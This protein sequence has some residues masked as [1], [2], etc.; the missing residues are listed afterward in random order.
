MS[1][2]LGK[3][4]QKKQYW[5]ASKLWIEFHVLFNCLTICFFILL[6]LAQC[7][8]K[9]K[10]QPKKKKIQI[11]TQRWHSVYVNFMLFFLLV[12]VYR[13]WMSA[14][15]AGIIRNYKI[16]W[17]FRFNSFAAWNLN[18]NDRYCLIDCNEKQNRVKYEWINNCNAI[19]FWLVR[20]HLVISEFIVFASLTVCTQ[21]LNLE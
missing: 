16:F 7:R 6:D 17:S 14:F 13:H 21:V 20:W 19:L 15:F 8:Y 2:T 12:L 11:K 1:C 9:K 5:C 3:L 18:W 10:C 4:S